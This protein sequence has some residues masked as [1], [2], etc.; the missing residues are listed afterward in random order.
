M[1]DGSLYNQY[2]Q[3]GGHFS[4]FFIMANTDIPFPLTFGKPET[5]TFFL[6]GVVI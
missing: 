2:L 3:N 5:Q 6:G 4:I 1:H